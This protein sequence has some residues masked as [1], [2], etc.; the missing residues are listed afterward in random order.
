MSIE[1]KQPSPSQMIIEPNFS[2]KQWMME[3]FDLIKF[4]LLNHLK[5]VL[6]ATLMGSILG[7]AYSYIK[8]PKFIADTI[9][10]VEESKSMGGGGLLSSLGGSLGMDITGLTGSNNTVLSGDNVL[11]LLK[12]KAFMTQ[13]LKMP[14]L[15]D[16]NYS[17]ADKYADIYKYRSEWKNDSKIGRV[18]SFAKPDNDQRL[19]DSLLKIIVTRIEEK[20]L[21]VVKPDKKLGFFKM[22]VITREEN[23]SKLISENLL[24]IATDFYIEAKVGRIR[25]NMARLEKRTDSIYNL[26][27]YKT[28]ATR[29]DAL[30]LLN[31][32]FAN[33]NEAI[34]SEISQRDKS[35]LTGIY[36]ELLK[37]LEATKASLI[38]ETP[39]V[40]I[41]DSPNFPLEKNETKWYMGLLMGSLFSFF[42]SLLYFLVFGKTDKKTF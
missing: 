33:V 35:V 8:S 26:L 36:G 16:S 17:I 9:F 21:S 37:N 10:L 14:Y 5:I 13:C 41:V 20:E 42:G 22:T 23:L 18:I 38:Q 30:L 24:K 6:L 28:Q 7:I 2:I 3:W 11:E 4:A 31:G 40:Q 1:N 12:S 15:N 34:N 32:N 27:N 19:Q 29:Q 25:K 39:T